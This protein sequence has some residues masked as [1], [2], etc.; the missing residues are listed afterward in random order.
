MADIEPANVVPPRRRWFAMVPI[1]GMVAAAALGLHALLVY[2]AIC[3]FTDRNGHSRCSQ[4]DIMRVTEIK[5]A[6][7]VW[8]AK[9]LLISARLIDETHC[10]SDDGGNAANRYRVIH[11]A[12]H[13]PAL[14][15]AVT[16]S[17]LTPQDAQGVIPQDAQ[18]V[19][20]QDAQQRD[21]KNTINQIN[22]EKRRGSLESQTGRC[23]PLHSNAEHK[24]NAEPAIPAIRDAVAYDAAVK[25]SKR[26]NWLAGLNAKV[27]R[28]LSGHEREEAW[29]A[30]AEA[31]NAETRA[32]TP[33]WARKVLDGLDKRF[34]RT[35]AASR[36]DHG[37]RRE[38]GGRGHQIPESV[39]VLNH[40]GVH[41]HNFGSAQKV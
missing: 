14:G 4:R 16:P 22:G 12:E 35:L 11:I 7:H 29:E 19:I 15:H 21:T 1:E 23:A 31:S 28:L 18:G 41:A 3:L 33:K 32:A 37:G 25:A 30:I 34:R 5:D 17:R 2:I 24:A 40:Q 9:A 10:R 6:R 39:G 27:S 20:P 13:T 38:Q 26:R 8:R 36:N